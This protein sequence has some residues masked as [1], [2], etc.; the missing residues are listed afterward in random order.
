MTTEQVLTDPEAPDDGDEKLKA[1]GVVHANPVDPE[2]DITS[3]PVAIM[4]IVGVNTT[5][6]LT[7]E[8]ATATLLSDKAG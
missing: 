3:L 7:C 8:A 1:E 2:S 6:R 4:L 5:D